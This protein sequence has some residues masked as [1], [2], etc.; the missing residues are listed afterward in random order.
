MTKD[1]FNEILEQ[2]ITSIR[3][4]LEAKGD[5]YSSDKDRLHNFKSGAE[6]ENFSKTPAEVCWG[7]FLKHLVSIRDLIE[8]NK[9][10]NLSGHGRINEKIGDAINYLI[11]LEAILKEYA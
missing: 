8:V 10:G 2:R 4:V 11:L 6:L 7:F 5:E 9:C 1:Q 3:E